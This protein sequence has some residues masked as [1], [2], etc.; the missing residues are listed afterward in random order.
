M[1]KN[2]KNTFAERLSEELEHIDLCFVYSTQA[3]IAVRIDNDQYTLIWDEFYW[4]YYR[5]YLMAVG[6]VGKIKCRSLRQLLR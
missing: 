6:T 1:N 4:K 3:R 5:K 2:I